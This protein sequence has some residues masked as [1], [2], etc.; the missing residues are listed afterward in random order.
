M[1]G[2]ILRA[3]SKRLTLA[4]ALFP[5]IAYSPAA[6]RICLGRILQR[7]IVSGRPA[8]LDKAITVTI[9]VGRSCANDRDART[10]VEVGAFTRGGG[11]FPIAESSDRRLIVKFGFHR[12]SPFVSCVVI[13]ANLTRVSTS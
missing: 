13:L 5:S 6:F 12:R 3:V 2:A 11:I 8:S 7:P 9:G 10:R 1:N 4:R